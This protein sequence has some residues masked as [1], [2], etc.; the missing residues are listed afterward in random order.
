M[1]FKK[2]SLFNVAIIAFNLYM[3]FSDLNWFSLIQFALAG[4]LIWFEVKQ[5]LNYRLLA[6]LRRHIAENTFIIEDIDRVLADPRA[7]AALPPHVFI[8]LVE[9]HRSRLIHTDN[10]NW[11]R[12]GF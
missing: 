5:Q 11:K 1:D 8:L 6:R 12:D 2:I 3:G 7:M 10:V 4:F 9:V